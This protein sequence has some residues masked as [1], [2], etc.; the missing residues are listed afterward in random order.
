MNSSKKKLLHSI[1]YINC[2]K[3][4]QYTLHFLSNINKYNSKTKNYLI[5]PAFPPA[6]NDEGNES[7]PETFFKALPLLFVKNIVV[8][9]ILN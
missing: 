7:G 1:N 2:K 3:A 8:S 9:G 5:G 6:A 4:F